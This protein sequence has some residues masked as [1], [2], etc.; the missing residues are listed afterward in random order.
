M[1][2]LNELQADTFKYFPKGLLPDLQ[3]PQAWL[4]ILALVH[5]GVCWQVVAAS[6]IAFQ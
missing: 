3:P 1:E 4:T 6:C 5:S 2:M